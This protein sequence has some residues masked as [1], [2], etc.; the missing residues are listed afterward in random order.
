MTNKELAVQLYSSLLQA[1]A[2]VYSNP[3]FEGPVGTPSFETAVEEIGK[4]TKLLAA[5]KDE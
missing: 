5:I 4:L 1:R 3:K 2:F